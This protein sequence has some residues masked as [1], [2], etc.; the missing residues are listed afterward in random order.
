MLQGFWGFPSSMT[1]NR[2]QVPP[3]TLETRYS[4]DKLFVDSLLPGRSS[5]A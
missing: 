2:I 3:D 1:A 4:V 5:I